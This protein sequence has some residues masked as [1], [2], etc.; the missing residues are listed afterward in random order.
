MSLIGPIY[1]NCSRERY[2]KRIK[3]LERLL[4]N[5]MISQL[6]PVKDKIRFGRFY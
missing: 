5:D 4:E 3:C 2:K 6:R 1:R